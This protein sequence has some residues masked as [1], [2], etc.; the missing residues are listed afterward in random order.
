MFPFDERSPLDPS[1]IR[2][3]TAALT[4]RGMGK[5]EMTQIATIIELTLLASKDK[6]MLKKMKAEVVKLTKKFP[7]NS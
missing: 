5:K 1:G 6:A 2:L 4:T 3:G 7:F